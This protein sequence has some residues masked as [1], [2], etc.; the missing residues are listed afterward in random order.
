MAK[1]NTKSQPFI[2]NIRLV[3]IID[4]IPFKNSMIF[5]FF[6][7]IA[8]ILSASLYAFAQNSPFSGFGVGLLTA[9]GNVA[10]QLGGSTGVSTSS[11]FFVNQINPA[12][13]VRNGSVIFDASYNFK[14][15]QLRNASVSENFTTGNLNSVI[16]ALPIN[17]KWTSAIALKP[18]SSIEYQIENSGRVEN[19]DFF[20]YYTYRGEGGLNNLFW[21][22]GIALNSK[23]SIGAKMNYFFGNLTQES[24]TELIAAG[25]NSRIAYLQ[26]NN[27]NQ[28]AFAVGLAYRHHIEKDRKFL[29]IGITYDLASNARTRRFEAF[30]K[31]DIFQSGVLPTF[32]DTLTMMRGKTF[33]PARLRVGMSFEKLNDYTISLEVSHQDWSRYKIFD[34]AVPAL[35][36]QT[37]IALGGE[38]TP[39]SRSNNFFQRNTYRIG[40]QHTPSILKVNTQNVA[41]TSLSLGTSMAF[42]GGQGKLTYVH[43]GVVGGQ[44]GSLANGGMQERFVE[45]KLGVS[46]SDILWFYRP[47]ID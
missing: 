23:L 8:I 30:E 45:A 9:E 18:Y 43:L 33:L 6:Q 35:S 1:I 46:L 44:R 19:S 2:K 21:S 25:Q 28:I 47:K 24:I 39:D 36:P 42:S 26:R 17:K 31:R 13:L 37:T 5:R 10:Q 34:V 3:K 4:K 32:I 20:A 15:Q 7:I 12:L 14:Y 41:Q 11:A 16:L 27:I 38:W 22:N 40:F 29:N